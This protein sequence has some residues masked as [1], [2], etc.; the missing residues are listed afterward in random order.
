MIKEKHNQAYIRFF[1]LY[2]TLMLKRHFRRIRLIGKVPERNVPIL[3]IAN[4]FSWWDGFLQYQI[5]KNNLH[6]RFHVMMLEEQ[7]QK[8]R[9]L[10]R[11][12]AF[13]IKKNSR[14]IVESL[15]HCV[16]ILQDPAN[17]LL[18]FPQGQIQTMHTR[19]FK[20]EKG[21]EF[22][23]ARVD[24]VQVVFNINLVDYFSDKKPELSIYFE[25]CPI[26][27]CGK[28]I[29]IQTAF[30]EFAERGIARQVVE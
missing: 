15:K 13:S 30:N 21:L 6:R 4:H 24:K 14:G 12:G 11:V 7:L 26:A 8:Y 20:F 1:D 9:F 18:L 22:I 2:S 28:S 29:D 3:M 23:L 16:D 25:E 17:I 19:D 27:K 5:N 10:R